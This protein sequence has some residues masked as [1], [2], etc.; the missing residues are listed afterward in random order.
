MTSE[1]RAVCT[2]RAGR[3][4]WQDHAT[5]CA[6]GRLARR[7]EARWRRARLR[8]YGAIVF[9]GVCAGFAITHLLVR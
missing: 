2:C 1:L 6:F 3:Q 9:F 8:L 5:T 4:S 7:R